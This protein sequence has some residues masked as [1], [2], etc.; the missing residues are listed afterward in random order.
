MDKTQWQDELTPLLRTS[1]IVVAALVVG[2]A[3]FA[4]IA[5]VWAQDVAQSGNADTPLLTILAFAFA[6]MAIAA[7]IVVPWILTAIAR[8]K[9]VAGTWKPPQGK[10]GY[11]DLTGFLEKTGDAGKMAVV[12]QVRLIVASAILEGAAFFALITYLIEP[13]W[14][15]LVLA[16]VLIVGLAIQMPTRGRLVEQDRQL[17]G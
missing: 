5:T 15:S 8:R 3:T 10:P 11:L 7:R 12:F 17:A 9:L 14:P 6:A 16:I 1:Q 2:S 13:W 4:V